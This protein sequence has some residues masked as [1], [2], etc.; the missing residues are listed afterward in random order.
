MR[1]RERI[2]RYHR[3]PRRS[4]PIESAKLRHPSHGLRLV[5]QIDEILDEID[6]V[7]EANT[8]ELDENSG[9]R[10]TR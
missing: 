8:E 4:T 6:E 2:D 1:R 7:L 3:R 10:D 9:R 5:P